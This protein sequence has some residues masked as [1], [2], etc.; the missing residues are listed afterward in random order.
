MKLN[1]EANP[2]GGANTP[3]IKALFKNSPCRK[4]LNSSISNSPIQSPAIKKHVLGPAKRNSIDGIASRL[5]ADKVETSSRSSDSS[6][7]QMETEPSVEV[8][9][10]ENSCITLD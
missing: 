4:N 10:K 7:S 8:N 9:G 1:D 6:N 3:T 5:L 2:E